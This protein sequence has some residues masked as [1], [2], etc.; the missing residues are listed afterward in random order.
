VAVKGEGLEKAAAGGGA[1]AS[2]GVPALIAGG[3]CILILVLFATLLS[4]STLALNYQP[5]PGSTTT[6][7]TTTPSTST[8]VACG[9]K[10][11]DKN[12]VAPA[13][14]K[15]DVNPNSSGP[16]TTEISSN[17]Y[18]RSTFFGCSGGHTDGSQDNC[19][20]Y[21]PTLKSIESTKGT[22]NLKGLK[23]PAYQQ[24]LGY[25]AANVDQFG[26][27]TRLKITNPKTGKAVVVVVIDRGPN[28]RVQHQHLVADMS[29][30]AQWTIGSPETVKM[31]KVA[32][33]T[34]IGPVEACTTK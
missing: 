3:G 29:W 14:T 2:L 10:S 5:K 25:F 18:Y 15:C 27:G 23:G 20:G 6:T 21:C 13:M 7:T 33:D 32:K 34:P 4:A 9:E 22:I 11:T 31:E 24:K 28:C 12:Q 1:L 30:L 16:T 26:C 8:A 19:S 17:S